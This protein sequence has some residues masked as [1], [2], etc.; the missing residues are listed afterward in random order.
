MVI[1]G[2]ADGID[3]GAAVV[4]DDKLASVVLQ[5]QCDG[6]PR[7][8]AFPWEAVDEAL[9]TAGVSVSDV[10]MVGVGGR[11]NPTLM[12]RRFPWLRDVAG[13]AF[14]PAHD[15]QVFYQ[16]MLR[17]SGF[18]AL[19][20]VS[21]ED[22]IGARF[23]ERGYRPQRVITVDTHKA[24]SQAAYRCQPRDRIAVM[25]LHPKGDGVALAVHLGAA[26]QL[27]L[28]WSQKGFSS[29]H[30]YL[31]RC[32]AAIG[33]SP[34]QD[35]RRV[36]S[37]AAYGQ[38]DLSLLSELRR[39]LSVRGLGLSR[40]A[41]PV[42]VSRHD[43][44]FDRLRAADPDVAAASI[45]A[46]LRG[47][48]EQLV[49]GHLKRFETRH[50]AVGGSV[51]DNP[52]V[53]AWIAEMDEVESLECAPGPGFSSLAVGAAMSL[54]GT[55]PQRVTGWLGAGV[56]DAAASAAMS[57]AG[58]APVRAPDPVEIIAGGGALMRFRGRHGLGPTGLGNRAVLCR[59]DRPEAIRRVRQALG[60]GPRV[61]PI[62]IARDPSAFEQIAK[63][64]GP[65]AVGAVAPRLGGLET[66]AW[67]AVLA[68]DRRARVLWID[69]DRAGL[70]ELIAAVGQKTG[71]PA[72][73]AF[74]LEQSERSVAVTPGAALELWT[75]TGIEALQLG[76]FYAQTSS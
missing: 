36:W 50:L 8:R 51:F 70:G 25:T 20:A 59:A 52:R 2:I 53:C 54:A 62:V 76:R 63:M 31:R 40:R 68:P 57:A 38:V 7:S 45:L 16:A 66:A 21:A 56:D 41:Y 67:N 17:Q 30:V 10:A 22:W 73:A 72:L 60:L 69:D 47:V 3:A 42:P 4:V 61:E 33:F 12:L 14:S 18:G 71:S 9:K 15:V 44:L 74:P 64:S 75:R 39:H 43:P 19:R 24:L 6:L 37:L 65:A 49:R 55:A 46:N 28:M 29:L 58:I 34:D 26:G 48:V 1:V 23:D 35:M 32:L 13:D 27:D 5:E 11:Y